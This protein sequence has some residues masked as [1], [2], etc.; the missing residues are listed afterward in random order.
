M[1]RIN[2]TEGKYYT[3]VGDMISLAWIAEA[4]RDTDEAVSFYAKGANHSILRLLDQDVGNEPTGEEVVIGA[5][6]EKELREAGARLR[7]DYMREGLG[8]RATTDR[9]AAYR[10]PRVDIPAADL[11]WA[12]AARQ[13]AGGDELVLLFPQTFW[14]ARAWPA[15]Y[16]VDLAWELHRR[17][18]ATVIM[19]GD[20][21]ERFDNTPCF[22]WGLEF[23]KVAALMSLA[24]LTVGNDSAP[25]HLS[26]TMGVRSLVTA[27]PT[28][29]SCVFGH[30]P[31][32]IALT[33][34]EAPHCAGCH[35]QPPFRAACDQGCQ[36]LFALKL[37]TVLGRVISELTLVSR[38]RRA[39]GLN[40]VCNDAHRCRE[41][42]D[43]LIVTG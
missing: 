19:L 5:A 37:H 3:G 42:C 21:D 32:V 43:E 14:K 8:L 4:R 38:D 13:K 11:D 20:K 1:P 10:R 25:V 31:E 40:R 18:V 35:F 30:I 9:D 17:N 16:W 7:L 12:H 22:F 36:A 29:S 27:G 23:T 39:D 2:T 33:N 15:S 41:S 28:R 34:D 24:K 6:Y 26:G